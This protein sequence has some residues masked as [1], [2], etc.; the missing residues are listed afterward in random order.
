MLCGE[1][2]AEHAGRELTL[3]GWVGRRRDHGGLVFIDLRDRSGHVQLV[4][5][6]ERASAAHAAAQALRLECVVRARGELVLRS[7]ATRNEQL[8][9][10]DVELV[11]GE[12]ELL[13]SSEV[14][15]FQLDDEGVDETLR[16]RHRYLDLRRPRMQELQ[17]I[18]TR[19]VRSIRRFL[20]ERGFLDLETPTMTRA[21]PEGARDFVIPFRLEPGTFYALPQSPQLYKQLLMCGGFDRYYQIARCWRDEA[22]RADRALEFTQ[23]DLEMSFVEQEDVL[24]LTEQ[25]MAEVWRDAGHEVELPF[26]RV[27]YREALARYGSDKPDLRYGL[28]I[29][30]VSEQVAGSEFGVFARAVGA[31]GV[32]RCLSV[33]GAAEALSRKDYDELAAFAQEW[34][35]KGLAYL[36]FEPDGGVRSPIAKFLSEAEI[37]AIR[38][39]SGA[40]PGS[41]AFIA[42]DAQP[43]VERVLGALR[44]H[45]ARR[46]D[47]IPAGQ[48]RFLFVVDF[49]LFKQ[50]EEGS[51]WTA[52]HHP[53]TAPKREHEAL[54]ERSRR[55]P[56]RVVRHGPERPRDGLGVDPHQPRGV[57]DARSGRDR[58]RSG[59]GRGPLRVPAARPA[60]R[61][62][63]ARRHRSRH[64][65]HRDAARRHGQSPR[66]GRV[67]EAR[68]RC[69]S[70]HR[71]TGAA[72]AR[73]ARR[74]RARGRA[75]ARGVASPRERFT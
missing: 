75:Q 63:A 17:A 2:R 35:G 43:V 54:R 7:D 36:I 14:L 74:A 34:G 8:P 71:R 26:P 40:A 49:P 48:W 53:F 46:F 25:L 31:G 20:D 55:G 38:E 61:R 11:V 60:L 45:L 41:V 72:A 23:L 4:I 69:R 28:E 27:P 3:S 42:A 66:G 16:I 70:A 18:R 5:D 37:A 12:I 39:A 1:P 65:P 33:P 19:A 9:T 52:E 6:P 44:P 51:G 68:R 30:D 15:P 32:V 64:R 73:A 13:S 22:Q 10:G 57:A 67:P 58:D 24:S 21:T 47:L 59:R 29:G 56:L 50:T 62:A